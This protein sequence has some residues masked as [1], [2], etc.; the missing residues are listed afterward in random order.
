MPFNMTAFLFLLSS[1]SPS[2][3]TKFPFNARASAIA[4][5]S[6]DSGHIRIQNKIKK[7]VAKI[8]RDERQT[9][10]ESYLWKWKTHLEG[11]L[12]KNLF[13]NDLS[14]NLIILMWRLYLVGFC[15]IRAPWPSQVT[16][17]STHFLTVVVAFQMEKQKFRLRSFPFNLSASSHS[18]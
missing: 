4:C 17:Y 18:S 15:C 11:W 6:R 2:Y 10:K 14:D 7:T 13:R 12:Q 5:S 8:E 1:S 9:E 16:L 3:F